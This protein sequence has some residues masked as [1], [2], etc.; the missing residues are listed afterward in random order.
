MFLGLK[1][2]E[3]VIQVNPSTEYLE[4]VVNFPSAKRIVVELKDVAC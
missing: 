3:L 2:I 4:P 1:G